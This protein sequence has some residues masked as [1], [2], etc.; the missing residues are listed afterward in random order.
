LKL[1]FWV[2]EPS[3]QEVIDDLKME[4]LLEAM[5]LER[6]RVEKKEDFGPV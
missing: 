4:M 3:W 1:K 5:R 2:K 6:K